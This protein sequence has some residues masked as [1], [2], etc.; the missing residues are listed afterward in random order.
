MM[1][2][3][4]MSIIRPIPDENTSEA[5]MFGSQYMF[6]K[7]SKYFWDQTQDIMDRE[8]VKLL[9][10]I[11][12]PEFAVFVVKHRPDMIY[13]T[14]PPINEPDRIRDLWT[15]RQIIAWGTG[16][17]LLEVYRTENQMWAMMHGISEYS[18]H[19]LEHGISQQEWKAATLGFDLP[20]EYD[21]IRAIADHDAIRSGKEM[22][23]ILDEESQRRAEKDRFRR[24]YA[25]FL[26]GELDEGTEDS[27]VDRIQLFREED[28]LLEAEIDFSETDGHDERTPIG[29]FVA[30][31]I[32][33]WARDSLEWIVSKG[34]EKTA[35]CDG[36]FEALRRLAH[37]R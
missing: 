19:L 23:G 4:G 5:I 20:I 15:L 14:D 9:A 2:S 25:R 33:L 21:T 10:S 11:R 32:L 13:A 16:E 12:D 18:S 1:Q 6:A 30:G 22:S 7:S 31:F 24:E 35:P 36:R 8:I 34:M 26:N 29:T 28:E 17:E 37:A 3:E 27:P